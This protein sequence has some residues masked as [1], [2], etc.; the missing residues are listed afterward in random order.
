MPL[1]RS[2]SSSILRMNS[3]MPLLAMVAALLCFALIGCGG[4]TSSPAPTTP[5]PP[6]STPPPPPSSSVTVSLSPQLSAVTTSQPQALTATLVGGTGSV[7][8]FVDDVE[9]G[10]ASVGTI[11]SAS[12]TTATYSPSASTTPGSH[13]ITAQVSGG[14]RSPAVV[15]AV[16]DLAGVFTHHNDNART[17]QNTK[18]YALTPLTVSAATFGKRFSCTLDSPGYVYAQPLYV[19]NLAMNDGKEHNIVFVAT[20][21]NWVYAIDADSSSCQQLWKQNLLLAGESTVPPG[22]VGGSHDIIPEI[23]ITSTPVIDVQSGII[24]VCAKSKGTSGYAHRLHALQLASGADAIASV[25]ITAP[26][27]VALYHLQRPALLLSNGT[28]YVAFGSHGDD[29]TY[30][31]WLM[32]YDA[33]T[34]TQ[35]FAWSATDASNGNNQGAIWQSGA[36]PATDSA[37]NVYLETANG[38]FDADSGGSNFSDSVV[39][40]SA[41]G[42]VLDYFT[43]FNE[44]VLNAGDVD[45]GSTAPLLLPDAMG[46]AAHPHLLI[47]AGKPG[48]LFLLDQANLGK[49]NSIVSQ[50][51]QEVNVLNATL[52]VG[53]VFGQPAYWNGNLYTAAFADYL[54]QFTMASGSISSNPQSHSGNIYKIRGATPVISANNTSGG[55]VW[56]VDISSYPSGPA[57]LN[58][59]DATNVATLLYSSPTSGAGAAGN[60]I[61]F[62][63]PTVA[64]G[65]VYVGT[66]GQLDV[67]GI[68]PN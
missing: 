11:A 53:G 35:K 64:N 48:T 44:S 2:L 12:D 51:L 38:E 66:Q 17:G 54:K 20:E 22:D 34:L 45:L 62:A 67:F 39:K 59:Y 60:A 27:F 49:F 29:N 47:A 56:A 28:V 63:V 5:P 40:L 26:N 61:K 14:V 24:Y 58:A 65:R 46:S 4:G 1:A 21:S 50:D 37:G 57:V 41:T 6:A 43:P 18:E 23:G 32:A 55:I 8:W 33:A 16:T 52:G 36:G 3:R 7:L 30:Q 15:V 68:L 19:G 13:S 25:E 42:T 10:N 31:G 9:N